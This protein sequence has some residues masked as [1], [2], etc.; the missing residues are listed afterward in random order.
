MSTREQGDTSQPIQGQDDLVQ[1]IASGA[2]PKSAWRIGTEHEKFGF[3]TDTLTP[4]P[5]EGPRGIRALLEAMIERFGW[6]PILENGN[7]IALKRPKGD[8]PDNG[9]GG[10]NISLEPGGQFEL[11]GAPLETLHQTAA[12]AAQ[13]LAEVRDRKSTRLNSSHLRLSRMPS[14]A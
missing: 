9:F 7:P 14:S 4:L 13:H 10:G 1:W 12:E 8:E 3:H 5:Y 11:S 6:E 2:K